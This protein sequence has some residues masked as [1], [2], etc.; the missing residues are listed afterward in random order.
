V[1]GNSAMSCLSSSDEVVRRGLADL[2]KDPD[3]TVDDIVLSYVTGI[4]DDLVEDDNE[5]LFDSEGF[6]EMLVAYLPQAGDIPSTDISQWMLTLAR[7]HR[8]AIAKGKENKN[9]F[10]LKMLTT[11]IPTST[12]NKP[13]QAKA[14]PPSQTGSLRSKTSSESSDG[15]CLSGGADGGSRKPRL[16]SESTE[17]HEEEYHNLVARLLEMFP[18]SCELEVG[19]CLTMMNGDLERTSNL[20]IQ[21][22]ETGQS[23][24]PDLNKKILIGK[25]SQLD[26]RA[27]RQKI[28]GK[29]GY[30]DQEDDA[31]YHRPI[32]KKET[33]KK[34]IRYRDGKIVSTKGE[35]FTQVTKQESEEMKKSYKF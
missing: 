30:V 11:A 23:L 8:A 25:D 9:G 20:I 13:Q 31:R 3:L 17:S 34:M 28:V 22:Y 33:D 4:L 18:N 16:I 32:I 19:H 27:L 5:E 26:E 35:R 10:D 7:T 29:Y 24:K 2:L 21:R 12:T 15:S 6:C 1:A 14:A